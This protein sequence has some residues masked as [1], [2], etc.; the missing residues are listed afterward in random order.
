MKYKQILPIALNTAVASKVKCY[1]IVN[2]RNY[3]ISNTIHLSSP[4]SPRRR[5]CNS[6]RHLPRPQGTQALP[7]LLPGKRLTSAILHFIILTFF[8]FLVLLL[9]LLIKFLFLLLSLKGLNL[10]FLCKEKVIIHN[11]YCYYSHLLPR[12]PPHP[13]HLPPHQ[14]PR[15]PPPRS[16]GTQFHPH[17][18][19]KRLITAMNFV[20]ILTF[21]LVLLFFLL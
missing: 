18:P 10:I 20:S 5:S 17:L 9:V 15:L 19:R 21:F 8:I 2:K 3:C 11:S 7:P 4:R 14:I 16:R 1:F 6:H 13:P 12:P